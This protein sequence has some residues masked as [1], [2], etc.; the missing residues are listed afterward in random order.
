VVV[1]ADTSQVTDLSAQL[2][3]THARRDG[4]IEAIDQVALVGQ[5]LEQLGLLGRS[6][7]SDVRD[8]RAGEHHRLRVGA[9]AGGGAPRGGRMDMEPRV[10]TGPECVVSERGSIRARHRLQRIEHAPVQ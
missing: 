9:G 5:Q 8:R 3:R 10:V 2:H 1:A 4:V 6:A 7:R